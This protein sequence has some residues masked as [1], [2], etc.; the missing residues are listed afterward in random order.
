MKTKEGKIAYDKATFILSVIGFIGSI[1]FYV[2][3]LRQVYSGEDERMEQLEHEN[4][5]LRQEV[6]ELRANMVYHE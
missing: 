5:E 4:R 1:G 6:D 3:V 2:G